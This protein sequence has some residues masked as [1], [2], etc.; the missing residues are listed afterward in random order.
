MISK[1]LHAFQ[2]NIRHW[3]TSLNIALLSSRWARLIIW[4]GFQHIFSSGKKQQQMKLPLWT[5]VLIIEWPVPT[6]YILNILYIMTHTHTHTHTHA[7][8]H[9]TLHNAMPTGGWAYLV[10]H[11]AGWHALTCLSGSRTLLSV[12]VNVSYFSNA[13]GIGET[14]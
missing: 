11:G 8:A 2:N 7:H 3:T 6:I 9:T 13:V 4:N 1:K 12:C 10:K 5:N 14:G